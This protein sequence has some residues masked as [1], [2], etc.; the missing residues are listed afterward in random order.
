MKRIIRFTYAAIKRHGAARWTVRKGVIDIN[1][2]YVVCVSSS[3]INGLY[4]N[5]KDYPYFVELSNGT[6]LLIYLHDFGTGADG[7]TI[8][9]AGEAANAFVAPE[10]YNKVSF[11]MLNQ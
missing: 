4:T 7:E 9:E 6:K 2:N 3:E 8:S 10:V 1:T 5:G 11:S